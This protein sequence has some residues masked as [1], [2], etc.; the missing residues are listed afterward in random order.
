MQQLRNINYYNVAQIG[1]NSHVAQWRRQHLMQILYMT[2]EHR[3][4]E[5]E[6][7]VTFLE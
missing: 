2:F 6:V 5:P 1:H 4:K 7:A 3:L